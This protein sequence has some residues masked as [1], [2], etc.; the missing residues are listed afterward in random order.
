MNY[1][2]EAVLTTLLNKRSLFICDIMDLTVISKIV[3]SKIKLKEI[4]C[5]RF[6]KYPFS[7]LKYN[8]YVCFFSGLPLR[9]E[10]RL[11]P[12]E[13]SSLNGLN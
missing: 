8:K 10:V 9:S 3:F 4:P 6:L 11:H 13:E 12:S 7:F 5:Q 1:C 2:T